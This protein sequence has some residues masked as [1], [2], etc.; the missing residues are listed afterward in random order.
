M[1][2]FKQLSIPVIQAPM[3]G[4]VCTPELVAAVANAGGVG[5]FGF[6]Y[7]TPEKINA[8]LTAAKQLTDGPVNAN[9]F[10][11]RPVEL[12]SPEIQRE[13]VQALKSFPI[14]A[15][16]SIRVPEKDFFLVLE[17]QIEPIWQHRPAVV[18]FHF[19]TPPASIIQKAHAL[20]IAVGI[21][22][23]NIAEARAIE[24]AGA[25]F[26]VA[27]GIQ[28]GGHR[29]TFEPN[30][31]EDENLTTIE[32]AKQIATHCQIP[33]VT[34]GAIM[35]GA[36]IRRA[37]DSGATAAKLGTA[38][39]CCNESGA[40]AA[41]KDFL[42]SQQHRASANDKGLL[43]QACQ[44][45]RKRL[46]ALDGEPKHIAV[47]STKHPDRRAPAMGYPN[48]QW[49]VSK[50]LGWQRIPSSPSDVG[51]K[52]NVSFGARNTIKCDDGRLILKKNKYTLVF[53]SLNGLHVAIKRPYL[54][55]LR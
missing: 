37:L 45:H 25:D 19:A 13:A 4:G 3:A 53:F 51:R 16:C 18:T 36:D 50:S 46:H 33:I 24:Q 52:A 29:G 44:G 42:V 34:A 27:Q 5:S 40:S 9:F 39:L 30:A 6:A 38:F 17:E 41:H 55:I 49:R 11:F 12:P 28:A 1:F 23:T 14:D 10:V 7:S 8:D 2:E 48:Q 43:R 31:D 20:G 22:A 35:D 15:D 47:S 26:I 32:L 21:T 54:H